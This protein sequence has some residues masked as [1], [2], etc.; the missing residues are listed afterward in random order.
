MRRATPPSKQ[1]FANV[2]ADRRSM[3][4]IYKNE[5]LN[6]NLWIRNLDQVFGSVAGEMIPYPEKVSRKGGEGG[7]RRGTSP[8]L[9]GE[10]EHYEEMEA[11]SGICYFT[12]APMTGERDGDKRMWRAWLGRPAEVDVVG[13][14]FF[15][16]FDIKLRGNYCFD[17]FNRKG[18]FLTIWI[19]GLFF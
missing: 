16:K 10:Q 9:C 2:T 6:P 5:K 19:K 1:P 17:N 15:F 4:A 18:T 3:D 8:V 11:G 13:A 14:L 12:A 7:G